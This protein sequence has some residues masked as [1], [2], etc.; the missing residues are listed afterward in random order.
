VQWANILIGAVLLLFGRRLFWLFVG[1][2]GF[3]V[4]FDLAGQMFHG[5]SQGLILLIAIVIGLL[6]AIASIFLQRVV[7]AIAGF[8]AS[9]YFLS[10]AA[11]V[12]LPNSS[13]AVPWLAF[14]AGGIIGAMLTAALLDPA[15][16]LLSSLAGATAI[17][18]NV[19]LEEGSKG[20]LFLGLVVFGIVAQA[21]QYSRTTRRR[22]A[23]SRE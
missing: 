2:V 14:V 13:G 11:T 19:P 9:G 1:G 5:M 23:A 12:A 6:G 7:V 8:F 18:Q 22:P 15:L 16:I 3:I 20:I 17:S 21:A 10:A 4:G